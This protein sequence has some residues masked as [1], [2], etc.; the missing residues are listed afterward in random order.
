M[1]VREQREAQHLSSFCKLLLIL[2]VIFNSVVRHS[3]ALTSYN[4]HTLLD[5]KLR[6]T[7]TD[8]D[9][10]LDLH[11]LPPELLRS[12]ASSESASPTGSARRRR[13]KRKQRRGKRSGLGAKLFASM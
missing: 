13:C 7:N 11:L 6:Y 8:V 2:L 3:F 9:T 10:T 5:I 12:L 1:V 4:R